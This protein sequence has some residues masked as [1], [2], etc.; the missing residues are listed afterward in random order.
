MLK[1]NR[2]SKD[3]PYCKGCIHA[4]PHTLEDIQKVSNAAGPCTE[5]S[6]CFNLRAVVKCEPI[7]E[8]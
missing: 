7:K 3:Q 4:R 8:D 5:G 1:C 6:V 2:A